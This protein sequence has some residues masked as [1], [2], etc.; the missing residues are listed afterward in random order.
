[1]PRPFF[2]E[3]FTFHNPDG[4]EIRVRG[5]GDQFAAVFETLDG[6]TVVK[7]PVS[8]F[9]H[10]ATLSEDKENLIPTESLAGAVDAQTLGLPK[11]IRIRGEIA[12]AKAQAARNEPR[13]RRRWEIRRERRRAKPPGSPEEHMAGEPPPAAV[14]GNYVGCCIL[15]AFPD[16]PGTIAQQ[17]VT[18]FC[19]KAGYTGFGNNGSVYDYFL[20]VSDGKLKY[21]N[22]V[23]AYYVAKHNR[24]YYTDPSVPFGSRAR[25][26]IVE[27]LTDLK[28][29]G[30]NFDQ[31]SSDSGGY[32]YALNVFYAG[33]RVN[34]WSE[35]LWP[36]SWALATP[37]AGSATK[38]LSD[39][40]ITNMGTQLT[41]GTFCHEN[42][43]MVCDF[44]DLYDYG[45]QSTGIG[46]YC[47]MCY[48]G[49]DLNPTEVC[50]YLKHKAGWASKLTT[51][52]PGLTQ[53]V[54]AGSNDFLIHKKNAT[55][56]FILENRQQTG[57]DASLP[58]AG[59]AIFHVD[60]AMNGNEDEQMTA[61]QHYECSLEQADHRCDLEH[62]ANA[63]DSTD[64]FGA[65]AYPAFGD[66]TVPNSKW[67]DG[68]ASGLEIEQISVPG[69][70]MT[71]KTK[72][73]EEEMPSIA[74]TW[75][76]VEVDWGPTGSVVKAGPFT[77]NADGSWSYQYGGG[78][79]VQVGGMAAWNFTNAAGLIYTAN[80]NNDA[81]SGVMGYAKAN[82]I[83]GCFYAL[84][85]PVPAPFASMFAQQEGV[86]DVVTTAPLKEEKP[87]PVPEDVLVGA[88]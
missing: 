19:N 36:H 8:G 50:A 22:S 45:Y 5:W 39:Y 10:Y 35:G 13:I 24:S 59:L 74:G 18:D 64:L 32:V 62:N 14:A 15:V 72:G 16:V 83:K 58:D 21:T 44:P 25:E 65:P 69:P 82:G 71:I 68:S 78:R 29:K 40:Q 12:K 66:A 49:S 56:Y 77:F 1:M 28:A 52:A 34:N 70:T 27:A 86:G 60:E 81:M 6:Y 54:V 55:E 3:E 31:L 67:W 47:L 30:Y 57:R 53:A 87:A 38:K 61:T 42:G 63:G 46:D 41:L 4:S 79:W 2:G 76:V 80:V 73:K 48:G 88:K 7:D 26:L 23:T 85:V 37:F 43:H 75:A 51:V 84:R 17:E 20:A 33:A 9:Y 11:H